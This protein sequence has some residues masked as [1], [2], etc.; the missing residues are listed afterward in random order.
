MQTGIGLLG[1]RRAQ[2]FR[3]FRG[4]NPLPIRKFARTFAPRTTA[5]V[6]GWEPDSG[7]A[8]R[9]TRP[10]ARA[11]LRGPPSIEGRDDDP[12]PPADDPGHDRARLRPGDARQLPARG[13][14]ARPLP[15]RQPGP[16]D[17][18]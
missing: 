13:H 1:Y 18:P 4:A 2:H 14:G 10:C 7:V 9:V 11:L 12:A 5:A 15:P 3:G 6:P 8:V 17:A 16:P